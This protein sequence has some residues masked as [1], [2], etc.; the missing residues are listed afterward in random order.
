MT[1]GRAFALLA[2][3]LLGAGGCT[4]YETTT[5][6]PPK[7]AQKEPPTAEEI[8]RWVYDIGVLDGEILLIPLG[9]LIRNLSHVEA[10]LIEAT[11]D[12]N[13]QRRSNAA[14]VLGYARGSRKAKEALLRMMDDPEEDVRFEVASSLAM[15]GVKTSISILIEGLYHPNPIIRNRCIRRLRI[16]TL[17]F[18][19]YDPNAEKSRRDFFAD[20]WRRWWQE[21]A[22]AFK[23]PKVR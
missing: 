16:F 7:L 15:Y 12:R 5:T 20:Q 13:P 6:S 11:T 1:V 2:A 10:A 14:H 18:F 21:N 22:K 8:R 19:N 23:F 4:I 3:A 17:K 9:H